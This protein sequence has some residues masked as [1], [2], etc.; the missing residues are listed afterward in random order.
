[1]KGELLYSHSKSKIR[2]FWTSFYVVLLLISIFGIYLVT[3]RIRTH[4]IPNGQVELTI[5]YSKYLVGETISFQLKNDYN[6]PIY[7]SNNCPSEPLAVYRL[8]NDQWIRQHDTA[9]IE[10]C[11]NQNRQISIPANGTV[12]SS[13]A[14]WRN[15]FSKPGKYRVVAF[16]EYYNELPYQEFEIIAK[17][18]PQESSTANP[19]SSSNKSEHNAQTDSVPNSVQNP[20]P[21]PIVEPYTSKKS[22]SI[23]TTGGVVTVQYDN[24]T[25]YVTSI[26]PA[27]GCTYEG[28]R[29]GQQVEITFK[30]PGGE[31]Q[32]Q[33][34]MINGQLVQKVESGG[35]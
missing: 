14:P 1:M 15:L 11:P 16:V 8:D 20:S 12:N 33:L 32:L 18:Q 35:D 9:S 30:C 27:A 29:S 34:T 22:A 13:F 21:N 24:S 5:P 23:P 7:L 17:P 4:T 6:S 2:I 10:E 31:T 19:S 28:G 25:I 26:A 3:S